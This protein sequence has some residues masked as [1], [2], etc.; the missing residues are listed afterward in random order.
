MQPAG[1][2]AR[3]SAGS[4]PPKT[5][6]TKREQRPGRPSASRRFRRAAA[7]MS[8]PRLGRRGQNGDRDQQAQRRSGQRPVNRRQVAADELV[9]SD[10]E[11]RPRVPETSPR[12]CR[13]RRRRAL[14]RPARHQRTPEMRPTTTK[15]ASDTIIAPRFGIDRRALL[16]RRGAVCNTPWNVPNANDQGE[17]AP[18]DAEPAHAV[19][20]A[21]T[22]HTAE[23]RG[24]DRGRR[25]AARGCGGSVRPDIR[26]RPCSCS[27][28][29]T[30][31]SARSGS[32]MP[33]RKVVTN[34]PRMSKQQPCAVDGGDRQTCSQRGTGRS[35]R[36]P[37]R[38]LIG[39][40][41]RSERRLLSEDHR[42]TGRDT[43]CLDGVERPA[44]IDERVGRLAQLARVLA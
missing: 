16:T 41:E 37:S 30:A 5:I 27:P 11:R 13:P 18:T 43:V 20:A 9:E 3:A 25:R 42:P 39:E 14:A 1:H 10:A 32:A 34:P 2:R 17:T 15:T 31:R 7:G 36:G 35:P 19:V 21:R 23:G 28:D 22:A 12:P 33:T 40:C 4:T 6:W 8:G 24:P 26:N 44:L 29:T 38:G